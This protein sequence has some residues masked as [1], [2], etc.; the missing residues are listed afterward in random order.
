MSQNEKTQI[1]LFDIEKMKE[2]LNIIKEK[3]IE[4][5]LEK[6]D[7]KDLEYSFS[8][9]KEIILSLDRLESFIRNTDILQKLVLGKTKENLI[10]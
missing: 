4:P 3:C 5:V 10:N 7:A 6:I 9:I 8:D 1:A 2:D